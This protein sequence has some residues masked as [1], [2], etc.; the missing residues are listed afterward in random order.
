MN[1][2]ADGLMAFWSSIEPANQL[3][4]LRWHNCEHIPERVSIPGFLR[5]RRYRSV[6]DPE[7]FLMFY[8]T[9]DDAVLSS[10]AYLAALNAPSRRTRD[11]LGWFTKSTR[12]VFRLGDTAGAAPQWTAPVLVT[13]RFVPGGVGTAPTLAALLDGGRFARVRTWRAHVDSAS[14]RTSESAIHGARADASSLLLGESTRL[15]LLDVAEA[16]AE[17]RRALAAALAIAPDDASIEVYSL[18][19]ALE[20][21]AAAHGRD[22]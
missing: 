20:A 18:E 17:S 15:D 6:A 1:A 22:G 12:T 14:G 7:R 8:E 13:A 21:P 5:G 2:Q 19:F 10:P 3:A 11:A 4:F 16:Q 9:R